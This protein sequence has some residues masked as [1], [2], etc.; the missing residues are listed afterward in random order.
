MDFQDSPEEAAYRAE[1]RRWLQQHA[2]AFVGNG[3]DPSDE[4]SRLARARVW[5]ALKAEARYARITWPRE[6][7]GA[8]GTAMQQVIFN[9][10]ES[11]FDDLPVGF[12]GIGLGMCV[13]TVMKYADDPTRLRF[14]GPAL[15]GEEIWCQLFSEPSAGSDV[16]AV[17][18]RAVLEED[19]WR[20]SGQKVWTTGAHYADH[21]LLL[22]RTDPSV[23]K[24]RGL[25]MFWI[26]MHAP[27]VSVRPIHQMSGG[28][29]FNEVYLDDVR[30][31]DSQ[32][33]GA[34]GEGWKV[35]LYTLMN[36]RVEGGKSR[37]PE[38]ET[39]MRLA[40]DV[41]A[42]NQSVMED[43]AFRERL[44]D[45]FVQSEGLK[46]TRFRTMT[47]LSRGETPGPEA[48][49]GKLVAANRLQDLCHQMVEEQGLF[50]LCSDPAV[51]ALGASLQHD[52][53]HSAGL[54]IAGGTDEVLKN[55]IAERVLGMP[56]D[57]RVDKD[58]P[59]N[60]LTR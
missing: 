11:R 17:R 55:I 41:P 33:L 12:F 10:E 37:G 54:R 48:A 13:P 26:D 14:V 32:R 38:I 49:I 7:G 56:P 43:I 31:S 44:A 45:W 4:A 35:A 42:G 59:F 46:Y 9:Q 47:A 8:G 52:L 6:W 2:P 53:L 24:H 34:V 21:G 36:E 57:V 30:V 51:A 60:Q 23:P 27:G 1:A 16:A 22:A 25:T 5:Q 40:S 28:S 50:G 19:G 58:V 3:G 29:D 18:T 15:R 39:I 20:V